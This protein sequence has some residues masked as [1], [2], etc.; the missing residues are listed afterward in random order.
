MNECGRVNRDRDIILRSEIKF[1]A[2]RSSFNALVLNVAGGLQLIHSQTTARVLT[3]RV[4]VTSDSEIIL[5]SSKD[6]NLHSHGNQ[7][8]S[9]R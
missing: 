7:P 5:I 4:C 3:F 6:H 1:H 2:K 8:Q 9:I